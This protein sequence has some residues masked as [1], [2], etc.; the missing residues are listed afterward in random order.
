MKTPHI[1]YIL[2]CT[3]LVLN[4]TH[5]LTTKNIEDLRKITAAVGV[6][7]IP[8]SM[9][10]QDADSKQT[11]HRL[12][13][14][15][16]IRQESTE[17]KNGLTTSFNAK[18]PEALWSSAVLMNQVLSAALEKDKSLMLKVSQRFWQVYNAKARDPIV[19]DSETHKIKNPKI[20]NIL[21]SQTIAE[22]GNI[23]VAEIALYKLLV[24]IQKRF[25][26]KKQMKTRRVLRVLAYTATSGLL[27][28]GTNYIDN[29][30][31]AKN[32]EREDLSVA[33]LMAMY[34]GHHT[35]VELLATAIAS[36]IDD[37]TDTAELVA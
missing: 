10:L 31:N 26:Y 8:V 11:N 18:L 34:L 3:T 23:L 6:V 14:C 25:P 28:A 1:I 35:A 7:G 12:V 29:A 17:D 2:A 30:F 37:T 5:A 27:A 16:H 4:N 19:V 24:L 15:P 21:S 13:A 33:K 36:Q 9:A 22:V 32:P 20:K